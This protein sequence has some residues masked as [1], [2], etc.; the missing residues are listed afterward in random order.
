MRSPLTDEVMLPTGRYQGARKWSARPAGVRINGLNVHHHAATSNAG[1]DR[2][3]KS[4]DPASANYI[5]RNN[6]SL[7]SSVPEEFR[8]WTTSA[9]KNDDDKITVEIQN[10]T[11]A[12]TWKISDAA[13]E[14]LVRLYADLAKRYKFEPSKSNIYGHRDYAAT[15]CPGPYLYPKLGDVARQAAALDGKVGKPSKPSTPSKPSKP[16][17]LVVDGFWGENVTRRAQQLLG[18]PRD[19]VVSNQTEAWKDSNQGLTSGWDWSGKAG[20]GGSKFI[21]EHQK[22]L[23]TRGLYRDKIDGKLGPN[24]IKALQKWVG[25]YP[26]GILGYKSLTVRKFQQKLNSGRI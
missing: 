24:Y 8:A 7:I 19:G 3:V 5:I 15:A 21:R 20:D 11:G 1:I 16:N 12:P 25:T 18:T 6:G 2:L 14:T 22:L 4:N 10:S 23:K 9:Y 13:Y 17:Q 26:D